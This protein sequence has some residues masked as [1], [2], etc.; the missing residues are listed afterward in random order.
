MP[1]KVTRA[2]R[3]VKPRPNSTGWWV[4]GTNR[5]MNYYRALSEGNYAHLAVAF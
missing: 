2:G 5:A 3:C 1:A 4:P